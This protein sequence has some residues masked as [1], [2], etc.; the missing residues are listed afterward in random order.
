[1]CKNLQMDALLLLAY[2]LH[3]FLHH[4]LLNKPHVTQFGVLQ[5]H[6]GDNFTE[7]NTVT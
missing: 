6:D 4:I 7:P 3:M 5:A 1:M 2:K